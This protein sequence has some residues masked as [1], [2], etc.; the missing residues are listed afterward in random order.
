M[1]PRAVA[2]RRAGAALGRAEAWGAC[3][4]TVVPADALLA[5][6]LPIVD[7][8]PLGR[9]RPHRTAPLRAARTGPLAATGP[10]PARCR[11][12]M[13]SGP[14]WPGG[15]VATAANLEQGTLG[16]AGRPLALAR[17]RGLMRSGPVWPGGS[18]ATAANLEQG[19]GPRAG[20]RA[21]S[22]AGGMLRGTRS[23]AGLTSRYATAARVGSQTPPALLE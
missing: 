18:V 10:V 7:D 17:C 22:R 20:R 9:N 4:G 5:G 2:T 8:R 23:G 14:V 6:G 19:A 13:R 11:G 3:S 1:R 12:L 16:Q 21:L 15:S